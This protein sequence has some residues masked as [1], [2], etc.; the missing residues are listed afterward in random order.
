MTISFEPSDD[1][2]A[3]VAH[4]GQVTWAVSSAK[5]REMGFTPLILP[6]RAEQ[7]KGNPAEV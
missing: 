1:L 2:S 6:K 7:N 3:L 5:H 4:F